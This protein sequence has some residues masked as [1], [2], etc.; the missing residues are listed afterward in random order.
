MIVLVFLLEICIILTAGEIEDTEKEIR[1]TLNLHDF[2]TYVDELFSRKEGV[3]RLN[4]S[5]T[6]SEKSGI[7]FET[8]ES[9]KEILSNPEWII[10]PNKEK[11]PLIVT[12][13]GGTMPS[14]I[15]DTFITPNMIKRVVRTKYNLQ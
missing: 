6:I 12:R 3:T 7:A 14:K 13:T 2:Y 10:F 5:K 4:N 15:N 9:F 11:M 8:C 1:L